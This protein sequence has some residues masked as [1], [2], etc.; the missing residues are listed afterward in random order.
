[1]QNFAE[2][3]MATF[4]IESYLQKKNAGKRGN[5]AVFVYCWVCV[6]AYAICLGRIFRLALRARSLR[7]TLSARFARA[8]SFGGRSG[9]F[10]GMCYYHKL[11]YQRGS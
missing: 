4:K 5:S 9:I 3:T 11:I 10:I 1:M 7:M 2:N 6:W 8:G